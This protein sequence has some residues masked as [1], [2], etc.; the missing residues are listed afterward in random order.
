[1]RRFLLT[2]SCLG[3]MVSIAAL[4]GSPAQA[5]DYPFCIKGYDYPAGSGDC[6]FESYEQCQAT[7]SGRLDF[8]DAN[9]FYRPSVEERPPYYAPPAR[10]HHP[11]TRRSEMK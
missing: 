9:P 4:V 11:A 2:A 5:R 1:M 6:S 7:A 10:R 3:A 8:C